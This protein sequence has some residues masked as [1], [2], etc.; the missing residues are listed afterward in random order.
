MLET[1][2]KQVI[3]WKSIGLLQEVKVLLTKESNLYNTNISEHQ[4]ICVR[5]CVIVTHSPFD[6]F[7][8]R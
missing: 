4:G 2:D 8:R 5:A 3:T 7:K 1:F 6:V